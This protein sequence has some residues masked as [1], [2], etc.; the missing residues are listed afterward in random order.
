MSTTPD[1]RDREVA[2]SIVI[3]SNRFRSGYNEIAELIA[4]YRAEIESAQAKRIETLQVALGKER[5]ESQRFLQRLGETVIERDHL[6]ERIATLEQ[7]LS[8][9][10][11]ALKDLLNHGTPVPHPYTGEPEPYQSNPELAEQALA[12]IRQSKGQA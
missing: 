2:R 1:E 7:A 8:E 12:S 9:A 10:E 6:K 11:Y 5:T 4:S 3:E